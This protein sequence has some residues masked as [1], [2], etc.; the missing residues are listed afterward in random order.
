MKIS[1]LDQIQTLSFSSGEAAQALG[2]THASARLACHRYARK[3]GLIRLK[4][5][6]YVLRERWNHLTDTDRYE[7]ANRL[8]VPSY[9]SLTSALSFHGVTTQV[10][11]DFV[12]SA[13]VTRTLDLEVRGLHF[14]YVK[15]Q[16]KLYWGFVKEGGLFMATPEKAFLDALYLMSLGRYRLDVSALDP[17][18]MNRK[19]VKKYLTRFPRATRDLF[20]KT[21][22]A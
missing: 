9:V 17:S 14:R 4:R 16:D 20:E 10:Q 7:L 2:L 22:K 5:D 15:I 21:C 19:L 8:Q 6:V 18:K 3:G 12:E 11:R 13:A 1:L